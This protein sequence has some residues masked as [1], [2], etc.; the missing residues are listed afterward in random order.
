MPQ[1]DLNTYVTNFFWSVIFVFT[2]YVLL[3]KMI[4]P[5][6]FTIF[7]YRNAFITR[8]LRKATVNRKR[9]DYYSSL[10]QFLESTLN[11]SL[12]SI[13][14]DKFKES[15]EYQN[16]IVLSALFDLTVSE[17]SVEQSFEITDKDSF[18][19]DPVLFY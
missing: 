9:L 11:Y 17:N 1:L 7:F 6:I 2:V 14:L 12:A 3:L 16:Q 5:R 15:L 10:Y 8:L 13:V 18:E 19:L 4:L